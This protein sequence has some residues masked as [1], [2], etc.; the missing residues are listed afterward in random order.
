MTEPDIVATDASAG[1][2][3]W[4]RFFYAA[5]V[6]N[7]LIGLAAMLV[8]ESTLDGRIIG[9][10]VF[11][12]GVIY[13]LVAGDPA[14]Y[15][16]TLWAGVIGKLGVVGLLG[17]NTFAADGDPLMITVLAIDLLFALG[18][19]IYLFGRSETDS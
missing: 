10:L 11:A 12:F 17:P 7:F 1:S 4:V 13:W 18:F 5:A 14:R 9:V 8:P 3:G 15:A 19:L 2:K 6:F 16:S